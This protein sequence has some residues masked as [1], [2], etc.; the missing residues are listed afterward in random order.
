MARLM[1]LFRSKSGSA[2]S[3]RESTD[4]LESQDEPYL[5]GIKLEEKRNPSFLSATVYP[6]VE[7][8]VVT[9]QRLY[10]SA[11]GE[12]CPATVP[13]SVRRNSIIP[14]SID[15][16]VLRSR[17]LNNEDDEDLI[18][19]VQKKITELEKE[20]EDILWSLSHSFSYNVSIDDRTDL[21]ND[22]IAETPKDSCK[23]EQS[24]SFEVEKT[25]L[26]KLAFDRNLVTM[27][28]LRNNL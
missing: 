18:I 11:E 22:S 8:K 5:D 6:V 9:A 21:A 7:E 10:S 2:T 17:L 19:A 4:S 1:S 20:N 14:T 25:E 27:K 3:A 15:H 24:V 26:M 13:V 16:N 23:T 28:S 12:S